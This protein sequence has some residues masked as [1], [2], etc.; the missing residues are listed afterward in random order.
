ALHT[1][2]ASAFA[3]R[4]GAIDVFGTLDAPGAG[5]LL[6]AIERALVVVARGLGDP[7]R[8]AGRWFRLGAAARAARTARTR[9]GSRAVRAGVVVG[10]GARRRISGAARRWRLNRRARR[11]GAAASARIH[12]GSA[13]RPSSSARR[14]APGLCG[15]SPAARRRAA[16]A[17]RALPLTSGKITRLTVVARDEGEGEQPEGERPATQGPHH[18]QQ[19]LRRGHGTIARKRCRPA[20]DSTSNSREFALGR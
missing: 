14:S 11:S 16:G 10:R 4:H 3:T 9:L 2:R 17:R 19:S 6:R 13:A 5:P 12:S 18:E 1:A 15:S 20:T 8:A 7:R